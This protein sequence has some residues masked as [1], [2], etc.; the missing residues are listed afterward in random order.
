MVSRAGGGPRL[1]HPQAHLQISSRSAKPFVDQ[2]N[3]SWSAS[4]ARGS[5]FS[6]LLV[7]CSCSNVDGALISTVLFDYKVSNLS[8]FFSC[9][10][11]FVCTVFCQFCVL[12][13]VDFLA[14]LILQVLEVSIS[15]VA[16]QL[17]LS[18]HL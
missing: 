7:S 15:N 1:P 18:T 11:Y 13:V 12:Q 8:V 2:Q 5:S 16:D 6:D 17:K 9:Y 14:L 10:D 4:L 3:L